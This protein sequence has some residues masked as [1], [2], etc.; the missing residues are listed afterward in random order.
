MSLGKNV[1]TASASATS[2]YTIHVTS[3]RWGNC[4]MKIRI[5]KELTKPTITERGMKRMSFA[6]PSTANTT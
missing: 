3:V 2:G 4:A 6:T 5:A 1:M